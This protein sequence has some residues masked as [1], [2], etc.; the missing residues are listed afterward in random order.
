MQMFVT[1]E[2]LKTICHERRK[3]VNNVT[4]SGNYSD[5][6]FSLFSVL[7]V[8]ILKHHLTPKAVSLQFSFGVWEGCDYRRQDVFTFNYFFH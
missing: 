8:K 1:L 6:H 5:D 7:M 4:Q 2:A 3:G